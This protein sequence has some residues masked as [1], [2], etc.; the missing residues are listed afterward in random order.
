MEKYREERPWGN[1]EQFCLNQQC[2]VKLINV[3]S[4]SELSLQYHHKRDEFWRIIVGNPIIFIDDKEIRAKAG[5]EFFINRETLHQI[6]TKDFAAQVLEIS[7]GEF[8]EKD[9]VRVKDRYNRD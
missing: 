4:D 9:I 6:K 1:F 3:K 8:D 7:F 5:D 2:S